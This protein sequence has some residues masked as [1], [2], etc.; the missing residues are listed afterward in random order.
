MALA[1]MPKAMARKRLIGLYGAQ[2]AQWPDPPGIARRD[3]M[4]LQCHF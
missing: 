1:G 2:D 3:R 4:F